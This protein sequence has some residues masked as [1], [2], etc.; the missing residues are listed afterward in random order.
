MVPVKHQPLERALRLGPVAAKM[1]RERRQPP[2][3]PGK[4]REQGPGAIGQRPDAG[5][6]DQE[7]AGAIGRRPDCT[8]PAAGEPGSEAGDEDEGRDGADHRGDERLGHGSG[9]REGGEV[10]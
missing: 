4:P 1:R 9:D 5:A 7:V 10:R 6:L 2:A 8:P 3:G